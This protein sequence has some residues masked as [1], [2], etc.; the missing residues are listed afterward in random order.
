MVDYAEQLLDSITAGC[1][2]SMGLVAHLNEHIPDDPM[3]ISLHH[4]QSVERA[5]D[6]V[7]EML[8]VLRCYR[9]EVLDGDELDEME[10]DVS[11]C[12]S[13]LEHS[14][15]VIHAT[16]HTIQALK[17]DSVSKTSL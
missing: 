11:D 7:V 9:T 17:S 1:R 5:Y 3:E 2:R 15:E 8:D 6:I 12:V 14:W 10:Q 16:Y 4:V 13:E